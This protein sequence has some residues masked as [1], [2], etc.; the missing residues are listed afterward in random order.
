MSMPRLV[1]P[2]AL[3]FFA[4]IGVVAPAHGQL[5]I[6]LDRPSWDPGSNFG[7]PGGFHASSFGYGVYGPRGFGYYTPLY[8]PGH[9]NFT[10]PSPAYDPAIG[11]LLGAPRGS[12]GNPN[13]FPVPPAPPLPWARNSPERQLLRRVFRRD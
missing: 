11:S 3:L 6:A 4:S 1:V 10:G 2:A 9:D 12:L 7:R 13:T 5:G 8:L